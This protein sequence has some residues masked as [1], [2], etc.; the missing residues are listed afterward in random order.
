MKT[1]IKNYINDNKENGLYLLPFPTGIG[2]SYEVVQYIAKKFKEL[3]NK[4]HIFFLTS[5]LNNLPIDD[6][7]KA[8]GESGE[9]SK[10][11]IVVES[12]ENYILKNFALNKI[13]EEFMHDCIYE[14]DRALK[15][16]KEIKKK[17][18]HDIEYVKKVQEEFNVSEKKFRL[19]I[20]NLVKQNI[21]KS[22]ALIKYDEEYS[23]N[24]LAN[25]TYNVL[26]NDERY[27]WIGECYPNIFVKDYKIIVMSVRKFFTMNMP[28][29]EPG[30]MYSAGEISKNGIIFIDEFDAT[31]NTI[32]DIL[33][34]QAM[35]NIADFVPLIEK[36]CNKVINYKDDAPAII[37]EAIEIHKN[38][39]NKV[40]QEANDLYEIFKINKKYY[41][42]EIKSKNFLFNDLSYHAVLEQSVN[43]YAYVEEDTKKN[44]MAIRLTS[45][46]KTVDAKNP[47]VPTYNLYTVIYFMNK[48]LSNF[49]R[50]TMDVSK[51]YKIMKNKTKDLS[52]DL[53]TDETA[54]Y[55]FLHV[56]GLSTDDAYLLINNYA[57]KKKKR[58]K[59]FNLFKKRN[60]FYDLGIKTYEFINKLESSESTSFNYINI[61]DTP[62]K[63]ISNLALKSKVIGISATCKIESVLCNYSLR[64]FKE[65]LQDDFH[66]IDEA[67]FNAIK[68][69][70]RKQNI[71]YCTID[72]PSGQIKTNICYVDEEISSLGE[73]LN[74][75]IETVFKEKNIVKKVKN[76]LM[77]CCGEKENQKYLTRRYMSVAYVFKEFVNNKDIKS[78]LCLTSALPKMNSD[79][80]LEM[81]ECLFKLII[82]ENGT[83]IN[84]NYLVV[85]KSGNEFEEKKDDV[86]KRLSNGEKIFL[87]SSYA[88]MGAGQNIPYIP[89]DGDRLINLNDIINNDDPRNLKKDFD[90]IYLGEITNI[91]TNLYNTDGKFT[92][93]DLFNYLTQIENL[94]ENDE[95]SFREKS[96][97]IRNGFIKMQKPK[98]PAKTCINRNRT[99]LSKTGYVTKQAV[100]AIGRLNRTFNK[101]ENIYIYISSSVYNNFDTDV[102]NREIVSPEIEN[103]CVFIGKNRDKISYKKNNNNAE[104][105]SFTTKNHIAK[106]LREDWD[107]ESIQYWKRL[108][109]IVLKYPL[110]NQKQHDKDIFFIE[111]YIHNDDNTKF[112]KYYFYETNDFSNIRIVFVDNKEDAIAFFNDSKKPLEE[113]YIK[114]CSYENS[115]L[116]KI[117][118]YPGLNNYFNEH[119]YATKFNNAEYMMCPVLF[120]NIYKGALGEVAGKYIIEKELG[121]GLQELEDENF[122]LFDYCLCEGIYIDFKHWKSNVVNAEEYLEKI[123][124][125][126]TKLGAK[127]VYII[128]MLDETGADNK[129]TETYEGRIVEV[130]YLICNESFEA[131]KDII[132]RLRGELYYE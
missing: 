74:K 53:L 110:V 123:N 59:E 108:R 117:L 118:K 130:P 106:R 36:I 98:V 3:D 64:Y 76:K 78:F 17:Y 29:F 91:F 26:K 73:D 41:C 49:K 9:D 127:R 119:G 85:I 50:F 81:I 20:N 89:A 8:L 69:M 99:F 24:E 112:N 14:L 34:D 16:Y 13:P 18:P 94:Y 11:F 84:D 114:E 6:F 52:D 60:S 122:E 105:I 116:E 77:L 66:I 115:R 67:N 31:K 4:Q 1:I 57:H 33:I 126:L 129:I 70:Y 19:Y 87:M 5:N 131:N 86:L 111:Y 42:E 21:K 95:L 125:K 7:K 28:F 35:N 30:Y 88:T 65:I 43:R 113:G 100:Q 10:N 22:F 80:N 109:E 62:E 61:E 71:K 107:C 54:T 124:N 47:N 48:F 93:K 55:S 96:M 121:V 56:F 37:K 72:N 128:N 25:N 68:E 92:Y 90:A 45:E 58:N 2:K 32:N 51:D 102:R 132:E 27:K 44:N 97:E 23:N 79:F 12:Y 103:L 40:Y 83:T 39:F 46:S 104:R 75:I 101:R 38:T 82:K 120:Q 15:R 63:I